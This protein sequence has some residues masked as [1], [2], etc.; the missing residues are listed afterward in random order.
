MNISTYEARIK[1]LED[2]LNPPGPGGSTGLLSVTVTP[3]ITLSDGTSLNAKLAALMP[4]APGK[5]ETITTLRT[6]SLNETY[7]VTIVPGSA[8]RVFTPTEGGGAPVYGDFGAA[9]TYNVSRNNDKVI[10]YASTIS[11]DVPEGS[12]P[13]EESQYASLNA[14]VSVGG[15]PK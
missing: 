5:V 6:P 3:D 4:M 10:I 1:A 9:L 2:Q 14:T 7:S 8:W 15:G 11:P 12:A 13:S